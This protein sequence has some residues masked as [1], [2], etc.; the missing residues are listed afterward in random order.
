MPVNLAHH[1]KLSRCGIFYFRMRVP[2]ALRPAIGKREI[3]HSLRTRSPAA[4]RKLA[5]DLTSKTY[6]LFEKMAYDP[7]KFNPA[8]V[9]T[10]PTADKVRPFELDLSKGIM[11]TNGTPEDQAAMMAALPYAM[12]ALKNAPAP[13]PAPAQYI[14][15]PP[16]HKISLGNAAAAYLPTLANLKTRNAAKR[17]INLFIDHRGDVEIHMVRGVDVVEWNN[18]LLTTPKSNGE[19]PKARSADNAI[20]FLQGMLRWA[21]K[22]EY[23]H[24]STAL[25][26]EG[27]FNLT[28]KLRNAA[29]KGA[30]HFTVEQL[31]QI[32]HYTTWNAFREGNLNRKWMPLI[33]LH[34]G[35][36]LEE[37]AQLTTKD[38]FTE[39]GSGVHYIDINR[40]GGKS[41]KTDTALRKIPIHNTLIR[42]GFLDYVRMCS[43][44]LFD[45]TGNAVSRA[46]IRY[47]VELGIKK[48]GDRGMVF[49]S[50]RD[51]FNNRLAE[52]GALVPERLRYALMG[53]SMT[54]NTNVMNYT[55]TIPVSDAKAWGIDKLDFVETVGGVTH[56]L[57]LVEAVELEKAVES[58]NPAPLPRRPHKGL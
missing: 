46:F 31:K 1:L 57:I 36:R 5:Y 55:K 34:T 58:V 52:P 2:P 32:F 12:E 7:H 29:T 4:A 19:M 21:F 27:K 40:K 50:F 41:V 10:F 45:E 28:K 16:A 9:S 35:M 38:I 23:I 30:N 3:L 11:R 15:P 25:A 22:N 54:D 48:D 14:E 53:H 56:T 47:L 51:T 6:A 49:H 37:I 33:A 13:A 43:G 20:Q 39:Q 44:K 18:I 42:L 24:H 17:A 8:D 26:T